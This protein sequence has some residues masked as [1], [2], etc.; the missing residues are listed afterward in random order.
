MEQILYGNPYKEKLVRDLKRRIHKQDLKPALLI[1]QVGDDHASN[2]YL[3][4]K[5]KLAEEIGIY[6]ELVKV[7]EDTS[8]RMLRARLLIRAKQL[9]IEGYSVGS[10]VQQ[11]VP[12]GFSLDFLSE[13]KFVARDVEGLSAEAMGKLHLSK[14]N[15][16]L[17]LPSTA[18]G[19]A[20]LLDFY[21]V[22]VEGKTVLVIGRSDIVGTPVARILENKNA[23][24][25]KAHSK[26]PTAT[27]SKLGKLADIVVVAIGVPHKITEVVISDNTVVIDA[28]INRKDKKVV[29]DVDIDRVL[30]YRTGIR[31]T[32]VPKG[33]GVVTVVELMQAVVE[34]AE[35]NRK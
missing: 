29:G 13:P 22:E 32:P 12:E 27:L 26:T 14:T 16:G 1:G 6:A 30:K 17:V 10:M 31:Y 18:I 7:D 2:I 11:P 25:I 19:I 24:V 28:G 9:E 4:N 33:V 21:D 15:E 34:L 23:T 5:L 3:R 8:P 35:R 20:N